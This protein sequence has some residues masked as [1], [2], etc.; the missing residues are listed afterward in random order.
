MSLADLESGY[1]GLI[2]DVKAQ[3]GDEEFRSILRKEILPNA[4]AY[5]P[6]SSSSK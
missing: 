6:Q 2:D 4:K 1:K 5:L 3:N